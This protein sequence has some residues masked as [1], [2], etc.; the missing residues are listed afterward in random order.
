MSHPPPLRIAA[1]RIE[2]FVTK[3]NWQPTTTLAPTVLMWCDDTFIAGFK[4]SV[5]A[6][7]AARLDPERV[8][9]AQA[10]AIARTLRDAGATAYAFFMEAWAAR[11]LDPRDPFA[12]PSPA[13][14]PDRYEVVFAS[15]ETK[16]GFTL[17][18][19]YS[20]ERR[21]DGTMR[22]LRYFETEQFSGRFSGL[23][24]RPDPARN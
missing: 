20:V 12:G 16:D 5:P 3:L 15:Y 23:L 14:R 8:K 24:R 17:A 19:Q 9:D 7:L 21:S 13:E 11:P 4:V 10:V 6:D 18:R 2:G 22:L 1:N